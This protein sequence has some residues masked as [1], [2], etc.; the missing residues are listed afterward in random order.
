MSD[1]ENEGGEYKSEEEK[2]AAEQF[3]KENTNEIPEQSGDNYLDQTQEKQNGFMDKLG[4]FYQEKKNWIKPI[5]AV[6]AA[7]GSAAVSTWLLGTAAPH[8]LDINRGNVANVENLSS[9]ESAYFALLAGGWGAVAGGMA[10]G[11]L[12]EGIHSIV[13]NIK[14]EK[15]TN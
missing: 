10:G 8:F 1:V 13:E 12:I 14:G 4:T 9:F 15:K 11:S 3:E 5:G 6:L 7:G 2:I